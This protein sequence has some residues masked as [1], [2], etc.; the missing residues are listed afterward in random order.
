MHFEMGSAKARTKDRSN[1][2]CTVLSQ[3]NFIKRLYWRCPFQNAQPNPTYPNI[4]FCVAYTYC[5]VV[6]ALLFQGD[7]WHISRSN[8]KLSNS[9]TYTL[10]KIVF[11][12]YFC[13]TT[14]IVINKNIG[15]G[16][17]YW[18][19]WLS[20]F[21]GAECHIDNGLKG[22]SFGTSRVRWLFLLCVVVVALC[23]WK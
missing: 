15:R 5:C 7:N 20:I 13:D 8:V 10:R 18:E 19:H 6:S 9:I 16:V 11:E 2:H 17:W 22:E 4:S 3:T 1:T 23:A 12:E 21:R 14:I